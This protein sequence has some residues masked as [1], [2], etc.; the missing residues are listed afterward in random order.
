M[1]SCKA[2][3]PATGSSPSP[4]WSNWSIC[5]APSSPSVKYREDIDLIERC[6]R[7]KLFAQVDGVSAGDHAAGVALAHSLVEPV[8]KDLRERVEKLRLAAGAGDRTGARQ[9]VA[10]TEG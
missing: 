5:S 6:V 2:R 3:S 8:L 4:R 10:L 1:Q 7:T 9:H